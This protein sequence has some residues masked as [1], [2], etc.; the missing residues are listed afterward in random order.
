MKIHLLMLKEFFKIY[1]VE[2]EPDFEY[3]IENLPEFLSPQKFYS[4]K[5]AINNQAV[6]VSKNKTFYVK[7]GS[8]VKFLSFSGTDGTNALSFDVNLNWRSIN[9]KRRI[10]YKV[11]DDF[12]ELFTIR[13]VVC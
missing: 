7:R 13:F 11:K 6:V 12:R 3:L 4:A 8:H 9:I 1:S 10:A 5:I 2:I